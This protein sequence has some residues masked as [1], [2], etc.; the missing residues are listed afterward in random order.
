MKIHKLNTI[1]KKSNNNKF[2]KGF[3]KYLSSLN[4]NE[5]SFL[6]N[7][8]MR[9]MTKLILKYKNKKIK[10]LSK[11]WF[12]NISLQ[13]KYQELYYIFYIANFPYIQKINKNLE[14]NNLKNRILLD[15]INDVKSSLENL[16]KKQININPYPTEK[17]MID[18]NILIIGTI[19]N[20]QMLDNLLEELNKNKKY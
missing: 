20:K 5:F 16:S 2:R 13:N 17:E 8:Y 11:D 15:N 18:F 9:V 3:I 1:L 4:F 7:F 6:Y 10:F 19:Y 12:K 14:I